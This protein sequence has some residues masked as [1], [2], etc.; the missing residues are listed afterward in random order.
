MGS[1][2]RM[3]R[4]RF[5]LAYWVTL[6]ASPVGGVLAVRRLLVDFLKICASAYDILMKHD[7]TVWYHPFPVSDVLPQ[8]ITFS[9]A[10]YN[11]LP[12][13]S[14]VESFMIVRGVPVDRDGAVRCKTHPI[15]RLTRKMRGVAMTS[16]AAEALALESAIDYSYWAGAVIREV[17]F[18]EFE[19]HCFNPSR[20]TPPMSPFSI[21]L[22]SEECDRAHLIS[23]RTNSQIR[24]LDGRMFIA[25][26]DYHGSNSD[27][28]AGEAT[29]S[30]YESHFPWILSR[31]LI[32]NV[33]FRCYR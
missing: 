24:S 23:S 14:S 2:I 13:C 32:M 18:G 30:V 26:V 3:L 17:T 6:I 8:L 16:L 4:P 20:I 33:A 10:G 12:G 15:S 28:A 19:Y 27:W 11:T 5:D 21:P 25:T 29:H 31:A 22:D 1:L 9:D 7:V